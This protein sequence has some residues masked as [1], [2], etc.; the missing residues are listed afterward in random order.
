MASLI[1]FCMAVYILV[2]PLCS[3][4]FISINVWVLLIF[5]YSFHYYVRL[6]LT[7]RL[8]LSCPSL[9]VKLTTKTNLHSRLN[10][11]LYRKLCACKNCKI[12]FVFF[13]IDLQATAL[14]I[15]A[16]KCKS[17]LTSYL[18]VSSEYKLSYPE[19]KQFCQLL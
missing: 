4:T 3:P 6:Y 18:R 19:C 12:G 9:T 13:H 2:Q 10:M 1:Y 7:N 17:N 16:A 15:S 11:L 8:L 5:A 14:Q